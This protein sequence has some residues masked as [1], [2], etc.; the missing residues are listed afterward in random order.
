MIK[1]VHCKK[2]PYT[3]LIDRTTK[4]GNPFRIG[5]DCSREESIRKHLEWLLDPKRIVIEKFDNQLVM[6]NIHL[7]KG[8]VLG[9]WCKPLPCHGDNLVYLIEL[10]EEID[11]C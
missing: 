6:D 8:Q 10:L 5:P 9:C 2:E 7:L 11:W 4:F 1:V 3:V